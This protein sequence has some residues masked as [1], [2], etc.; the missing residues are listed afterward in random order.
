MMGPQVV[1]ALSTPGLDTEE[2]A[3]IMDSILQF[4]PLYNL[5]TSARYAFVIL[6]LVGHGFTHHVFFI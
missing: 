4:F 2:A 3:Q 6:L 1:D 5:V